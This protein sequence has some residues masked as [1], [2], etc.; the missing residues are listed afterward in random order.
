MRTTTKADASIMADDPGKKGKKGQAAL[1][2][3]DFFY[4]FRFVQVGASLLAQ[5]GGRAV[6]YALL[7]RRLGT[8][9]KGDR[10]VR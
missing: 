8:E 5:E 9:Q 7:A 2:A 6:V 3:K 10:K 4:I 1:A